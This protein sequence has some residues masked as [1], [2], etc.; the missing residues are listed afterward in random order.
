MSDGAFL[1]LIAGL[2]LLSIWWSLWEQ[3]GHSVRRGRIGRAMD[4]MRDD[5]VTVGLTSVP[6]AA[7]PALSAGLGLVVSAAL[8]SLSG[9]VVPSVTIGAASMALPIVFLRS[10]A[11]RRTTELR[12]VWPEAVDHVNSA[13]RAGLSLPEALVQLSHKGPEG[14]RPAFH[15]FSLDYQASGDFAACL[16]R[17]KTRLADPVGDRI[18]EALRITRDVGGTDLGGLLRTLATFL[19]EDA[20]TR[21]ELEARQSWTIN[22]ARLALVAPWAVLALMSTRPQAAQAYDSPMGMSMILIGA[23]VSLVAYR[24]MLRIARLPQDERVLR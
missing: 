5:L 11:R 17:L 21:A 8:W 23:A 18:V 6:P 15:E 24:V 20:R 14:L 2:G 7:V 19:R 13:I 22:A 3:D 16:D 4:R 1:G 12:E 10:A 9:A